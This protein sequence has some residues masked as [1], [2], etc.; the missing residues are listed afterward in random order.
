M[1]AL[2]RLDV[3]GWQ[4]GQEA[5]V[6]FPDTMVKKGICEAGQ[7]EAEVEGGSK[8]WFHVCG[9]CHTIIAPTD[10]YCREC[11]KMIKW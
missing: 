4:I 8:V 3:P 1:N 10:K 5:S 2:I 6:Y 9:E 7:A 11:G